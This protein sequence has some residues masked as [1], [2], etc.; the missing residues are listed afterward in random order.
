M[1]GWLGFMISLIFVN[2]TKIRSGRDDGKGMVR[3]QLIFPILKKSDNSCL[4]LCMF[5]FSHFSLSSFNRLSFT[6]NCHV[7]ST[8]S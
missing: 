8:Q 4:V 2:S 6:K 3:D 7:F 5:D 1:R